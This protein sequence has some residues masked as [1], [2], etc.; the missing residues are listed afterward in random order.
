MVSPT[1]WLAPR[2]CRDCHLTFD[3]DTPQLRASASREE[4]TRQLVHLQELQR[5]IKKGAD[6]DNRERVRADVVAVALEHLR[7]AIDA[8]E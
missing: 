2:S 8:L 3:G 7:Q 1:D 4:L 5:G 6:A